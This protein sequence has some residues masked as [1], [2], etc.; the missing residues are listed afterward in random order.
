MKIKLTKSQ[1]KSLIKE[2]ASRQRRVFEL[3]KRKQ[4]IMNQLNEMYS[5][6]TDVEE[7]WLG[8][9]G[10]KIKQGATDAFFGSDEKWKAEL[11]KWFANNQKRFG[12]EN[13]VVP[14]TPEDWAEAIKAAKLNGDARIIK[15]NGKWVPTHKTVS[16]IGNAFD[17]SGTSE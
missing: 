10:N 16:G 1:L 4:E 5:M 14:T 15:K 6:D 7:G 2:E 3:E 9:F 17:G 12:I 11:E 8:D 13:I